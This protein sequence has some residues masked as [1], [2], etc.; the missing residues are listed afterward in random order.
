MTIYDSSV[1]WITFSISQHAFKPRVGVSKLCF[2]ALIKLLC[3]L[4]PIIPLHL[5]SNSPST[6]CCPTTISQVTQ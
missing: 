3:C 2:G 6:L 5:V 4:H 1:A